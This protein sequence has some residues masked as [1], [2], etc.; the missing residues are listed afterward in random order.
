VSDEDLASIPYAQL[1]LA[2]LGGTVREHR[3][4]D[5]PRVPGR[6]NELTARWSAELTAGRATSD[7]TRRRR[8]A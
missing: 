6:P 2:E 8:R 7:P 1:W 3:D 4:G 5:P